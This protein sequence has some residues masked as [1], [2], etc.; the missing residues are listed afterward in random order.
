M[1]YTSAIIIYFGFL[2]I[3]CEYPRVIS[4]SFGK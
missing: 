4:K 2:N 3:G 1:L